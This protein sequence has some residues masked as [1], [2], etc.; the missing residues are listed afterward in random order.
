MEEKPLPNHLR[1]AY[2]GEC[3]TLPV[4]ISASLTAMEKDKLL[5]IFL[6]H[7]DA[8]GWSL[9]DL[10]GIWPSMCMH[11]ILLEDGHKPLVEEQRR[12][13]LT[14]KEVVRKELLKWLDAGVIYPIF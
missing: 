9:A 13:N 11:R 8:I 12:P 4:I 3:S 1:Y 7:K 14:M 2:L 6:D 5:R 10:K